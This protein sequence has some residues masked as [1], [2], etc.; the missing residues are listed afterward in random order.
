M[1]VN[2]K[3]LAAGTIF[4]AIGALYGIQSL[5]L[6]P[7]TALRMGPGAFP[8]LLS[9]ALVVLG[10]AI[11]VRGINMPTGPFGVIPWRA[12]VFILAAPV[13]SG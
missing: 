7:G 4:A 12:L 8:T 6:D 11:A 1:R 3:D 2:A 5:T 13:C 9:G 10:I